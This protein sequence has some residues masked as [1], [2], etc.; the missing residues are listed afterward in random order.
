M[1]K[2]E[3]ERREWK[4]L[5]QIVNHL[6][7]N[8]LN[9][10][11]NPLS[12]QTKETSS[13]AT[14]QGKKGLQVEGQ[15]AI[16]TGAG[17]GIGEA[18]AKLFAREGSCVVV[19]D[20]DAVKSDK[21]AED[22]RSSGGKA[23][24][25]AGDVTD[26]NFPEKIINATLK[27]YGKIN[28]LVNNAGYTWDGMAHKM[29]DKQWEAMLLVHQT[30]PFRLIRAAAPY[31]R[32][33]GRKELERDGVSQNRCIINISSTSGLH[34]N[35]GQ[36]NYSTAKMGILGMTKTIAKE[37]G[38][39]GVRCN[40]VAFG[41]IETRLTQAKEKGAFI[42]VDG[43]QVALGIPGSNTDD[44]NSTKLQSIPLHRIGK[45]DEAAAGILL[46]ASPLSSYITG[47]CLEI[48]GGA[49]I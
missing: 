45:P 9:N 27:A 41:F 44:K 40:T 19:S 5:K 23:I 46:L 49:G 2:R 20:L 48:T 32:D 6:D 26:P 4:R 24:S 37:W 28:V 13:H 33:E 31:M 15:V 43:K 17:Q 1:E 7:V 25:V 42:T 10:N 11:N 34:G 3:E 21:V 16:I 47:H 30:A 14:T 8:Q 18:T 39:F 12:F 35:L 22:I 36:I 38:Q 29:S